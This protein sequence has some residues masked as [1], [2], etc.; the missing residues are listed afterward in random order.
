MNKLREMY[1]YK[2]SLLDKLNNQSVDYK[3]VPSEDMDELVLYPDNY[4]TDNVWFSFCK[5]YDLGNVE[6]TVEDSNGNDYGQYTEDEF[7]TFVKNFRVF[8]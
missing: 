1:Q 8:K 6:F 4:S 3:L 5:F 2:N 7:L